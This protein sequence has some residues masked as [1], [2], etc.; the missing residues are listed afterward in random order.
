MNCRASLNDLAM[1]N[2]WSVT[3]SEVGASG[4]PHAPT[5]ISACDLSDAEGTSLARGEGQGPTK[6]D[7]H[8]AAAAKVY[9]V[10]SSLETPVKAVEATMPNARATLHLWAQ[11]HGAHVHYE[12]IEQKGRH[13]TPSFQCAVA[14]RYAGSG[15]EVIPSQAGAHGHTIKEAQ[16]SAAQAALDAL[17]AAAPPPPPKG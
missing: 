4:P 11:A 6:H 1:K 5:F 12:Q 15:E 7:A 13:H 9:T 8:E 16:E 3:Y 2:R 17:N 14:M 10:A